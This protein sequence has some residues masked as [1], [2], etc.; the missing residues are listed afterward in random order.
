[1]H[2]LSSTV[3]PNLGYRTNK[4]LFECENPVTKLLLEKSTLMVLIL[5]HL[6]SFSQHLWPDKITPNWITKMIK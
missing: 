3:L 2:Y 4:F 1:M 5:F 6:V